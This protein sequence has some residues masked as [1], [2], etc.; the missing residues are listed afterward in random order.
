MIFNLTETANPEGFELDHVKVIHTNEL[1]SMKQI[2]EGSL[3][4]VYKA[5]YMME[6]VAVKRIQPDL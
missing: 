6:E 2:E 3:G 5:K 4:I 1:K